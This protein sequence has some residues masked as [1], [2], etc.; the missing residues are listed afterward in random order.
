MTNKRGGGGEKKEEGRREE[1]NGGWG[2][3]NSGEEKESVF[4]SCYDDCSVRE[5]LQLTCT[6][7]T[8][9]CVINLEDEMEEERERE[10]ERRKPEREG[11]E[12]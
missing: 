3:A 9:L 6:P 5:N 7:L 4:S 12:R 2:R 11:R 8:L 1:S 10:R